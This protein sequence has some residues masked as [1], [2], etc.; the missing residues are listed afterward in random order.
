MK[1]YIILISIYYVGGGEYWFLFI[2]KFSII[3]Y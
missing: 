1:K 3:K 2:V